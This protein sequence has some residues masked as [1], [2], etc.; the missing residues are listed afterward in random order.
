MT[1]VDIQE[2]RTR[3]D[4]IDADLYA[5]LLERAAMVDQVGALKSGDPV[6]RNPMRPAREA[7]IIRTLLSYDRK[8]LPVG[9]IVHL[10]RELISGFC[11]MQGNFSVAYH[12]RQEPDALRDLIRSH[13][14]SVTPVARCS[15]PAAVLNAVAANK[16]AVGIVDISSA[17]T[18]D[19]SPWWLTVAESDFCRIVGKIPFVTGE[20]LP[21]ISD[22]YYLI[23]DIDSENSG[24]DVSV[25]VITTSP[26]VSRATVS[27]LFKEIC[28]IDVK[29]PDVFDI[30][31]NGQRKHFVEIQGFYTS[32]AAEKFT[33]SL[34]EESGEKILN[35]AFIG[36]Y[37]RPLDLNKSESLAS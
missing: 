4:E 36:S 27:D 35:V 32:E 29:T 24:D 18:H 19:E 10:W 28:N 15:G 25:F 9:M 23:A 30:P 31:R 2:V 1:I 11:V 12:S 21:N 20:D 8:N 3:I 37:P 13:F 14:G 5:L 7:K 16:G 34:Q 26:D 22:D 6:I 17:G 33:V